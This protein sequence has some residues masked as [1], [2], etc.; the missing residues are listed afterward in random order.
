LKKLIGKMSVKPKERLIN[1][2]TPTLLRI[3]DEKI[4]LPLN[5][6][7]EGSSNLGTI[8]EENL[9]KKRIDKLNTKFCQESEKLVNFKIELERS[10]EKLFS[11]LFKQIG[12]YVEEIDKINATT[13]GKKSDFDKEVS[14]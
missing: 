1:S 6:I 5:Y 10:N 14:V 4:K 3:L 11:I 2:E 13:V 12:L 7:F 8:K 9:L